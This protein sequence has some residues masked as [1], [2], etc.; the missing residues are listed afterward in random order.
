MVELS[1]ILFGNSHMMLCTLTGTL[2]LHHLK[3]L[4]A[5]YVFNNLAIFKTITLIQWWIEWF[6]AF[7]TQ[8]IQVM[9]IIV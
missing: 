9:N 1:I 3:I 5:Y 2:N 6:R 7:Y 8:K 4:C